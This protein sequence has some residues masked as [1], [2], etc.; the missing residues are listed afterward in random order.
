MGFLLATYSGKSLIKWCDCVL[1]VAAAI[2]YRD[3]HIVVVTIF[4]HFEH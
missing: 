4:A 1:F 2:D 3:R